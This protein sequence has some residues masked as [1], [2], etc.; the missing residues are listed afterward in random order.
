MKK[1]LNYKVKLL[2]IFHID[3]FFFRYKISVNKN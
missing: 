1:I 2:A 3:I